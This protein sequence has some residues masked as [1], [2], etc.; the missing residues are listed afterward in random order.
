MKEKESDMHAGGC[1]CF[2]LGSIEQQDPLAA[3]LDFGGDAAGHRKLF[4]LYKS[5]F[6]DGVW[7]C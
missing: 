1:F 4:C 3:V 2:C 6:S 7:L 5:F